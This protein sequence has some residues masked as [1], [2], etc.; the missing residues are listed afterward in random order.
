MRFVLATALA[1]GLANAALAGAPP[2]TTACERLASL[3]LP[4]GTVTMAQPVA[5]GAFTPPAG[6]RGAA[7]GGRGCQ[8][9]SERGGENESHVVSS[10]SWREASPS[11][12]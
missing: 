2:E 12:G 11:P 8:G 3:A 5:G 1:I 10:F 4:N 6:G 7:G 9:K